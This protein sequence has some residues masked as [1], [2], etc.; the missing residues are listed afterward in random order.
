MATRENNKGGNSELHGKYWKC[1]DYV[2]NC[3]SNAVKSYESL[4]KEED[5]TEG[6]KRAKGILK[7]GL[8]EYAQM[9]RIKNWFDSFGGDHNDMEYRLNGGKTMNNWVDGTLKRETDA[10]KGPKK[11]KMETGLTNQFIKS[12]E[13]DNSKINKNS[14]K[15]KLP[16]L[17][18]DVKGQTW[19]GK[20]VYEEIKRIKKLITHKSKI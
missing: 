12:H 1:P 20:P 18:K 3:L 4:N 8:I 16:K 13:K 19:R 5:S 9:K 14:V 17:H 2:T 15:I 7:N 6:Y 11:I 10:I